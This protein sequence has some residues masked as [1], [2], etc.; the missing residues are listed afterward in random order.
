MPCFQHLLVRPGHL[1]EMHC[2]TYSATDAGWETD[3]SGPKRTAGRGMP[4]RPD[5]IPT[6]VYWAGFLAVPFLAPPFFAPPDF[7]GFAAAPVTTVVLASS[8]FAPAGTR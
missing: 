1:T 8:K 7:A 6:L 5:C 3:Y 4:Y 2:G